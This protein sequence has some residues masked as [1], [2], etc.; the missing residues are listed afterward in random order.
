MRA[1]YA[2]AYREVLALIRREG[3]AAAWRRA[4]R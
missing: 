2:A 1:L 3:E 4:A